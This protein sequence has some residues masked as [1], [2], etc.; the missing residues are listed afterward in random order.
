VLVVVV[1]GVVVVPLQQPG[2]HLS[3]ATYNNNNDNSSSSSSN[4]NDNDNDDNYYYY[5]YTRAM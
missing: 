4:D 3:Q 5:N 1:A 2:S